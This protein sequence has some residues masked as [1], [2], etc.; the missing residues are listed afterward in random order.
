MAG[1]DLGTLQVNVQVNG[2]QQAQSQLNSLN[3]SMQ[4]N[5][6]SMGALSSSAG[7]LGS[8]FM[9]SL[10]NVNLFGV[11]LGSL[12][13]AMGDSTA[14]AGILGGAVGALTTS[15][16]DLAV[17]GVQKA[18]DAMIEFAK[19]GVETAS[20]LVE[21]Q[22]VL[23]VTFVENAKSVDRW[24]KEQAQL[25]GLT[26]IQ[27]KKYASTYGAMLKSMGM[28]N[29]QIHEMSLRLT[30][31]TGDMAS[32]YNLD[33][34]DMFTKLKSGLSGAVVPL[35]SLGINLQVATLEQHAF[36]MG[37]EKEWKEMTLAEK[38]MIRYDYILKNTTDSHGDFLRTQ[39]TYANQ[40]RLLENAIN[41]VAGAF[42]KGLMP[43]LT[44]A[45]HTLIEFFKENKE[46]ITVFG[47]L[48]GSVLYGI[49]DV[50]KVITYAIKP[51]LDAINDISSAINF[52]GDTMNKVF[53]EPMKKMGKELEKFYQG[54][55]GKVKA[56]INYNGEEV[57]K[58]I[59]D[60]VEVAED[61]LGYLED[62]YAS[63]MYTKLQ[64]KQE[65]LEKKYNTE[66]L[67]GQK[68]IA[69][70]LAAY[71][72]QLERELALD[73]QKEEKKYN[74]KKYY[75][76]KGL[77]YVTYDENGKS[78]GRWVQ[79]H[80]TG[81]LY[82]RGGLALVGENGAELVKLNSGDRVYTHTQTRE[83]LSS[84]NSGVDKALMQTMI[85]KL[86]ELIRTTKN[87]P[88]TQ[89]ALSRL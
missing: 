34:E 65:Q 53:G 51:V 24:A 32:F 37:I 87:Q 82:S 86:D 76:E 26:E 56:N 9:N 42:G 84:A 60:M 78:V 30:A 43:A 54:I 7:G 89:M 14:M 20:D 11:N 47:K 35:R 72:K 12:A 18:I 29:E 1:I 15:F 59:N 16:I 69:R 57:E 10:S 6:S 31:L 39:E 41:D 25:F 38:T 3:T 74:I 80:A 61:A 88:Y 52:V 58:A 21:I 46:T 55:T 44:D 79:Q 83:I 62:I 81:T 73:R 4:S 67:A 23:D 8:A 75:N 13:G 5:Q 66:T 45:K 85:G 27:A 28:T 33:Y 63:Y 70:D 17:E 50:M 71:E 40:T 36:T 2:V 68:A 64:K 48:I 22:N 19:E 49:V 77:K